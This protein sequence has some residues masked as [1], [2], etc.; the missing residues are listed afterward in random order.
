MLANLLSQ[1]SRDL[2]KHNA[3]SAIDI[4]N[5]LIPF[6]T[7][8]SEHAKWIAQAWSAFIRRSKGSPL[9]SLLTHMLQ[10]TSTSPILEESIA[11][12]I[13]EAIQ[14][15]NYTLHSRTHHIFTFLVNYS[16]NNPTSSAS[17]ITIRVLIAAIHHIRDPAQ[18]KPI[19][20]AVVA[21]L[22]A[23]TSDTSD[24]SLSVAMRFAQVLMGVRKATRVDDVSRRSIFKLLLTLSTKSLQ[25]TT[26]IQYLQLLATALCAGK[27][28]DLLSPGI[29]ILDK[30]FSHRDKSSVL[31]FC[32]ALSELQWSGIEQFILPP[33][34]KTSFGDHQYELYTL[35]ATLA[36]RTQLPLANTVAHQ[37]FQAFFKTVNKDLCKCVQEATARIISNSSGNGDV[38]LLSNVALLVH[39]NVGVEAEQLSGDIMHLFDY[40]TSATTDTNV[41]EEFAHHP[42]NK[43]WLTSVTISIIAKLGR[44]ETVRERIN[45]IVMRYSKYAMIVRA[46]SQFCEQG[47]KP[48]LAPDAIEEL[49]L[50]ILTYSTELRLSSLKLLSQ[51]RGEYDSIYEKCFEVEQV[52]LTIESSRDRNLSLRRVGQHL[53]A[54]DASD[55]S[56]KVGAMFMLCEC[57]LLLK[58]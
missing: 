54:P 14:S 31:G 39:S 7:N 38:D 2:L 8:T 10:S 28:E 19:S 35:L 32:M 40:L 53:L 26:F 42:Y 57:L 6:I 12:S 30:V 17:S 37:R 51:L 4:Y 45:D 21:A 36:E 15:P 55:E 27:L 43:V 3:A 22:D 18:L 25:G 49:R 58:G 1:L 13:S 52:P 20:D 23:H 44:E 46:L 24:V 9:D 34:S 50:N 29:Q 5:I 33:M 56:R 48:M 41:Q 16:L 11:I 47:A